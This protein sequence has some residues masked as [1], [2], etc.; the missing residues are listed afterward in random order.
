M[1]FPKEWGAGVFEVPLVIG[2]TSH[3]NL[4]PGE[5]GAIRERVAEFFAQ[6]KREFP[7]MPLVVLS[8]LAEGG[9][10]L[11]A[12]EA[13][14]AGARLIA[15][16]PLLPHTYAEDFVDAATR[17]CFEELCAR[18]DVLQ[19][20][21][22]PEATHEDILRPGEARD[23]QYAQAG[24]F[25]ASHCHILLALWDGR[26][27]N[28]LGGTGQIVRY[29]LDG[30]M[31]GWIERRRS[32]RPMLN[33]V[34]ES[35]VYHLACSRLGADGEVLPPAT[36]LAPMQLRWLSQEQ[37]RD[38][39]TGMQAEFRRMFAHMREFDMDQRRY[40]AKILAGATQA[41]VDM[42]PEDDHSII[43]RLFCA[44]DALAIHF[45]KRVTWT[46]RSMHVL[47]AATGIVFVCYADLPAGFSWR[48]G[49]Y[50]F[51]ALFLLGG[52]LSWLARRRDW[53]R[54]YIDYRALAEGLRVQRCWR[55]AGVTTINPSVFAHDHFMQKTDLDLGWI[56]NVM[57][58]PSME[59]IGD[60]PVPDWALES[61]IA[62]WIGEVG[63]GGQLDY[64]N[65]KTEQRAR[66]QRTTRALGL[67]SLW[68]S[69]GTVLFLALFQDWIGDTITSLMLAI[70]AIIGIL[71]AARES[72][73]YRKGD[74]ELIKQYRFMLGIFTDARRKIDAEDD[75]TGKRRILRA[76]G[77]AA[78]SEHAEWALMHRRRPLDNARL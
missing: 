66:M 33:R 53:H 22:M 51:I 78:M 39:A 13:L 15:P 63:E 40:A 12:R 41:G 77:E 58:I 67:A 38:A 52:F 35:I 20:P 37:Q 61:V 23:R 72:Y 3:R 44:A 9:D 45:Q 26:D 73:A 11:V 70:L 25:I 74:K 42:F 5:V 6:L 29:A 57:R 21:L 56:R 36:P 16:L 4:V 24:V 31:P 62:D 69:F 10:Q 32:E 54:K 50:A 47:A 65:R 18:G 17:E 7:H 49:I 46:S 27:S 34:D 64:Y 14:V 75:N 59:R 30:I 76:L 8:S 1:A 68:L 60:A 43:D 48:S 71:A 2:V 28:L 55:R 19:M